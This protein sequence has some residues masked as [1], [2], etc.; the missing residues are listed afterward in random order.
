MMAAAA[1]DEITGVG[2]FQQPSQGH[3]DDVSAIFGRRVSLMG[4][5]KSTL[6]ARARSI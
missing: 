3:G 6:Q 4:V 5:E 1:G 2:A